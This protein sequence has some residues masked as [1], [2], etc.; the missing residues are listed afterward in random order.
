[1]ADPRVV[2]GFKPVTKELVY[3]IVT[4][5]SKGSRLK[6]IDGNEYLD[7]LNGFGSNMFGY[8]PDFIIKALKD[9]I[10]KGYEIG[11][12]HVLAGEVSKLICKLTKNERVGFCN[13]GS[14][15]VLG[16]MRIARTVSSKPLIVSFTGSYH[17]IIDEALVRVSK[18]GKTNPASPGILSEN[19]QQILVLE[20]GTDEALQVIK[21]R[22]EEIAGVLVEPVQSR[23]PEFVPIEFLQKL[24]SITESLDI[25]LIFDE[26]ITG[27]RAY[28]GGVQEGFNITADIATYGKVVGGGL[29][30][31]VIGGKAKWM[32]ALDGGF[33]QYGDDSFPPAGVTYFAGTFVRHP[34]ALAAAKASLL[35]MESK[36]A[37]L[38]EGISLLAEEL[39]E[40]L[41]QVFDKFNTPFYAVN[42]RSLWK[43]KVKDEFP[44]WELL[45][46][47]LRNEGIH[48]WENFPC[49]ITTAHVRSDIDFTIEKVEKVLVKLIEN[50]IVAGDLLDLEATLMDITYPPFPGAK[51]G[52]DED[53]NPCWIS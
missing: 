45:F 33:W 16:A 52:L 7:W 9:Q 1:M 43:I 10:D 48:I 47:L 8:G 3:P 35:E 39:V 38:Q 37:E 20:Y 15:A 28:P 24:R 42:F 23:R 4:E 19:V 32:D 29:P 30:I 49:F 51:I 34:L 41:N 12:Q 14:E 2:T 44:Y 18:S 50:E 21:D 53:G 17:G 46:T 27:F 11:P 36:G 26:V 25:C 13:T 31:G 40:R 6:D 22:S 5:S